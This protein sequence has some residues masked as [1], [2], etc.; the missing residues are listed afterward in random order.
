M[1]KADLKTEIQGVGITDVEAVQFEHQRKMKTV[2]DEVRKT[3]F[4]TLK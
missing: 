1:Y 3:L 2:H 4:S